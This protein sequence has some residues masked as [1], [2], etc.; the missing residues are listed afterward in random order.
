LQ[1]IAPVD[2]QDKVEVEFTLTVV[3]FAAKDSVTAGEGSTETVNHRFTLAF[4]PSHFKVKVAFAVKGPITSTP[5][6][7][8]DPDHAP[9][10]LHETAFVDDQ[11]RLTDSLSV[12]TSEGLAKKETV[13]VGGG[14]TASTVTHRSTR[15][16]GPSQLSVNV[17]VEG[18]GPTCSLP[19]FG[20]LPDQAPP[21]VHELVL[22]D[23]HVRVAG[24]PVSR[25]EGFAASDSAGTDAGFAPNTE[26][27]GET[28]RN[29]MSRV[30]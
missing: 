23:D 13:G 11:V 10:A 15:P 29:G 7:P 28:I 6:G 16:P 19:V 17:L 20:L 8:L 21:A 27:T 18:R 26:V 1:E 4:V 3:G 25:I 12:V 5:A 22:I 30:K 14:V 24:S 9:P 2:D